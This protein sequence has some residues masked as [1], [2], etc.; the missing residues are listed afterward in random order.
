MAHEAATAVAQSWLP[1][2][3][4]AILRGGGFADLSLTTRVVVFPQALGGQYFD[5]CGRNAHADGMITA[6]ELVTWQ[7]AVDDLTT[8]GDLFGTVDYCLFTARGLA[9]RFLAVASGGT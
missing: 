5:S 6:A 3:L 4:L 1:G 9:L 2:P 8:A 7:S